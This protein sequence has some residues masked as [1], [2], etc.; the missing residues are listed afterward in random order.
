MDERIV[1]I[2]SHG[3]LATD[4]IKIGQQQGRT[5]IGLD[6]PEIDI[7]NMVSVQQALDPR[8]PE[9][10]INTAAAHG[11]AQA[12][13]QEQQ[14]FFNVNALGVWNLAR[15]C[16][17]HDATLV[18][19]STDYVF[20]AE[21]SRAKP[22]T[23][24]DA[25]CPTNIYGASKVAGELLVR[26]FCPCHYILRVASLYGAAGCRAKSDSNFVK[27]TLGKIQ[28]G[29]NMKVVHDQ[30]MSPTWT[31]A[32]AHKTFELLDA[33]APYGLYHLAGRGTC[34]WYEFACEIVRLTG[35]KIVVEPSV[36]PADKPEDIFLRP[37]YTALDNANLRR[38]G[39]ANLPD[40]RE[41]LRAY[42]E[43]EGFG[44]GA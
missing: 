15:W 32:A 2:G 19:Y 40:W 7:T 37:R 4:L 41:S 22:Y 10:V 5:L 34:T 39:L 33:H 42:L 16:R 28:K 13:F 36:T 14:S 8:A 18:H 21:R 31:G 44:T 11:A 9:I 29:E 1:V 6:L 27:M 30:F 26:S 12:A 20:G 38:A 43:E 35:G 17:Q 25:P 3:Q 23:E 24:A